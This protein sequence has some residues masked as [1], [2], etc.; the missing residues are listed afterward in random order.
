MGKETIKVLVRPAPDDHDARAISFP[1]PE[2]VAA[3]EW[4]GF[5]IPID[6]EEVTFIVG[7]NEG[8][9]YHYPDFQDGRWVTLDWDADL[10][11]VLA[12]AEKS[13]IEF[14]KGRDY[15]VQF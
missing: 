14:L 8:G 7:R 13:L 9:Q 15:E 2:R 10:E 11:Q 4:L 5:D 6:G 3:S 12:A 1:Y